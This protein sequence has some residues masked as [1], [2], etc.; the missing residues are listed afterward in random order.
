[1]SEWGVAGTDFNAVNNCVKD[2]LIVRHRDV[3]NQVKKELYLPF[4]RNISSIVRILHRRDKSCEQEPS[5]LE[6]FCDIKRN[7]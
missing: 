5:N 7:Q 3:K 6:A 4:C 1:M 2:F